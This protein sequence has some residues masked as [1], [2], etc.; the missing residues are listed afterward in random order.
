[1]NIVKAEL[2]SGQYFRAV[3]PKRNIV[4]HHTVSSTAK[5]ALT[6]WGMTPD[7]VGTAF[8]IDKDGTIYQAFDP[9]YWAHHLGLKT[10]RNVELNR[11]SIG[12]ELVNEG[13]LL[14]HD[15]GFRWNFSSVSPKGS[16]Y[17]GETV[18]AMWRGFEWWAAYTP[19][20]YE[21]LNQLLPH[22]MAKFNLPG[23]MCRTLDFDPNT[24][25]RYTIYHHCNVRRDKSDISPAFDFTK[26]NLPITS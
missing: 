7:R 12:I 4:L 10:N 6:W 19:Q 16:A 15:G 8:V 23:T 24:P 11:C 21:A 14:K 3:F 26:I 9:Q 25:S 20:Q 1:M 2:P 18:Q 17:K 13:P 22:L 5:S